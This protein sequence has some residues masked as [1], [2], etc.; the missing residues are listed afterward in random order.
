MVSF[1]DNIFLDYLEPAITR[2]I[3]P[4]QEIGIIAFDMIQDEI[5]KKVKANRQ[6]LLSPEL[7]IRNSVRIL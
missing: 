2:V 3:Q 1:D 4:I 5:E 6:I 7:I